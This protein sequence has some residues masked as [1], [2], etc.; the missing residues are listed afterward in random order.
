MKFS[1]RQTVLAIA[2]F[3]L[4]LTFA[5]IW[6]PT[7]HDFYLDQDIDA[8]EDN[9][10]DKCLLYTGLTITAIATVVAAIKTRSKS[11]TFVRFM[12]TMMIFTGTALLFRETLLDIFLFTNRQL[13]TRNITKRYLVDS[14]SDYS[15]DK[16]D[17]SF[18]EIPYKPLR[19][20]QKLKNRIYSD[21]LKRNQVVTLPVKAGF[22]GI[23]FLETKYQKQD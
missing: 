18:V 19:P 5:W 3:G 10:L 11:Q 4:I 16:A 20:E 17:L 8:F 6:G 22:W 7:Q 1:R 14:Y 12:L 13:K 15:F 21:T 2:W 9:F 23:E